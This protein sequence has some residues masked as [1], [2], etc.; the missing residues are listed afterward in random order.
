MPRIL[1]VDDD[2]IVTSIRL[3]EIVESMGH[4]VVGAAV[5]GVEAIEMARKLNPD[6]ILMDIIMPGELD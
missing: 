5:S 2:D 1:V 6:L 3:I 4:E